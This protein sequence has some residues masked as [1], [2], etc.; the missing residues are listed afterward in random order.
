MFFFRCGDG[1][2]AAGH[3]DDAGAGEFLDAVGTDEFDE[4]I[5]F[6]LFAGEFDHDG[7]GADIND[8]ATEEVSELD[9]FATLSG[10]GRDFDQGQVAFDERE[11]LVVT[12]ADDGDDFC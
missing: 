3:G 7:I 10:G 1:G 4:G 6:F 5:D 9:D 12:D 11:V 2:T 8:M